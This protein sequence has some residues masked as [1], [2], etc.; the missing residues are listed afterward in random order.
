L[1]IVRLGFLDISSGLNAI[2]VPGSLDN[3][4]SCLLRFVLNQLRLLLLSS[5]SGYRKI[6]LL[7]CPQLYLSGLTSFPYV[8]R[9]TSFTDLVL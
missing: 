1:V 3:W 9:R 6:G 4:L 2:A 8:R 5:R 7:S